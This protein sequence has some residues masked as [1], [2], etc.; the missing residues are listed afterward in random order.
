VPSVEEFARP[1]SR[2]PY[3]TALAAADVGAAAGSVLISR[4]ASARSTDLDIANFTLILD[5][6]GAGYYGLAL[7]RELTG[8][9][10]SVDT[11]L[12]DHK[13]WHM[14]AII[15][16]LEGT[17]ATPVAKPE[18]VFPED[19]STSQTGLH[20]LAAI[21]EPLGLGAYPGAAPLI[22][23][24]D[25]LAAAGGIFGVAGEH[26]VAVTTTWCRACPPPSPDDPHVNS[27]P[28]TTLSV[29]QNWNPGGGAGTY[30]DHPVGVRYDARRQEW[31]IYNTDDSVIPDGASFNVAVSGYAQATVSDA[32]DPD[33][34]QDAKLTDGAGSKTTT[35]QEPRST[36][37]LEQED[38][39]TRHGPVGKPR[40]PLSTGTSSPKATSRHPPS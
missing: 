15:G 31:A 16:L 6:L 35:G 18:V 24:P 32:G 5:Y 22:Q 17:R 38:T 2:K 11:N 14:D 23:S 9:A 28:G 36:E 8:D 1:P 13:V 25:S 20:K 34:E 30:D 4:K 40:T 27:K 3:F 19:T 12:Y 7:A 26:V 10:L 37:A 33:A 29:T 39:E 21:F